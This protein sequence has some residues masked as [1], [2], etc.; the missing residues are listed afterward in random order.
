MNGKRDCRRTLKRVNILFYG[1]L[2]LLVLALMIGKIDGMLPVP[3]ILVPGIL[4][5]V[6]VIAGLVLA[7]VGLRCPHCGESLCL[8]GRLPTRLPNFCPRC[9]EPIGGSA[10][11]D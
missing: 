1:G 6:L 4:G 8:G 5:G 9:G 10:P 7:F 2:G 3:A 11:V